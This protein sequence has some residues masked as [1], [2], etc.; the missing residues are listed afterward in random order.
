MLRVEHSFLIYWRVVR[1]SPVPFVNKTNFRSY[2]PNRWI[3]VLKFGSI[4]G[5]LKQW[6]VTYWR[7]PY[8]H[9]FLIYFETNWYQYILVYVAKYDLDN[10]GISNC[11]LYWF[12]SPTDEYYQKTTFFQSP[13]TLSFVSGTAASFLK[14]IAANPYTTWMCSIFVKYWPRCFVDNLPCSSCN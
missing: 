10:T 12:L 4:V 8:S 14:A 7:C 2:R 11:I 3:Y 9:A 5:S 13:I 6:R 1:P